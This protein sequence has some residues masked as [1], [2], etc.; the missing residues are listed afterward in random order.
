MGSEEN[1]AE[2]KCS[3]DEQLA[4]R[5]G[6]LEFPA[7]PQFKEMHGGYCN[8]DPGTKEPWRQNR[9]GAVKV[10]TEGHCRKGDGSGKPDSCRNPSG[11]KAEPG[12]DD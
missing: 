8:D 11:E 1:A 2:D 7:H 5:D 4:Y 12:I 6:K 10:L 9:K 3:D